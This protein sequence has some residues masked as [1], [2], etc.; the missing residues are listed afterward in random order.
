MEMV[1][2][3]VDVGGSREGECV[4]HW[5]EDPAL[6]HASGRWTVTAPR[7]P[8]RFTDKIHLEVEAKLQVVS[9]V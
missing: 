8:P 3:H 1:T 2:G 4:L 5:K 6:M 9:S 7:H